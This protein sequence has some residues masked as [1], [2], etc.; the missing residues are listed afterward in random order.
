[1]NESLKTKKVL[2]LD[3]AREIAATK[4]TPAEIEQLRRKLLAEHGEAGKTG[5][6]YIAEVLKSEGWKVVLTQREEAEEEY[7]EEFEDLLHFKKLKDAEVSLTRLSEL[8]GKFPA[9]AWR[10]AAETVV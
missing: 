6:D 7:E 4:W 5:A 3:T 10:A 2:I 8:I 1:M 9:Q